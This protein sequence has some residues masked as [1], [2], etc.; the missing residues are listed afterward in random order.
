MPKITL[1]QRWGFWLTLQWRKH[2]VFVKI[3]ILILFF[4]LNSLFMIIA[5][6]SVLGVGNIE[7][8]PEIWKKIEK[9]KNKPEKRKEFFELY[10]KYHGYE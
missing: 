3:I 4:A 2:N 9:I 10:K 6:L 1:M 8:D 7:G 5:I